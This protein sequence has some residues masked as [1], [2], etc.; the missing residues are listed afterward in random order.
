MSLI[1]AV[2]VDCI[3]PRN[4]NK[5]LRFQIIDLDT[6]TSYNLTGHTVIMTLGTT[7]S[8]DGALVKPGTV[9]SPTLG[10]IMF[11]FVPEDTKD[12]LARSYDADI[13][14]KDTNTSMY[15]PGWSGTIAVTPFLIGEED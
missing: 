5:T 14:I 3:I 4:S 1:T 15:W 11:E 8:A 13:L 2:A 12:M 6:G 9:V 7:R 10:T